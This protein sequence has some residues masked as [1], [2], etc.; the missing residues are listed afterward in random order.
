MFPSSIYKESARRLPL[1]SHNVN[2]MD[3]RKRP[4]EAQKTRYIYVE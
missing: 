1:S 4:D 2:W 3:G